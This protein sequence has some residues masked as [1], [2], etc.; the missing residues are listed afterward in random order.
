MFE[1][2]SSA[3]QLQLCYICLYFIDSYQPNVELK[4]TPFQKETRSF[5]PHHLTLLAK[6]GAIYNIE[7]S[8]HYS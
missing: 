8:L 6:P 1:K 7:F 3:S 2:S 4:P 5:N